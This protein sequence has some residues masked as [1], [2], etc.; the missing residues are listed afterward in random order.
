MKI[1]DRRW[2]NRQDRRDP[3]FVL[4]TTEHEVLIKYLDKTTEWW[5]RDEYEA[6]T[7]DVP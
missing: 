3:H 7:E 1:L 2:T 5:P 4:R 6:N